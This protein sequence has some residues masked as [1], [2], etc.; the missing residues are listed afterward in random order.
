MGKAGEREIEKIQKWMV[1]RDREKK[2]N[3]IIKGIKI[4]KKLEKN[5]G[6][7]R[8]WIADLILKK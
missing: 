3:V 6:G 5:W 1:D 2:S 8:V 7:C 4:L